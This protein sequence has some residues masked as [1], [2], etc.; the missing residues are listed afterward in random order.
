M[1][2]MLFVVNLRR[3]LHQPLV[4]A[5]RGRAGLAPAARSEPGLAAGAAG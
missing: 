2:L 5:V 3:L 1:H 4:P